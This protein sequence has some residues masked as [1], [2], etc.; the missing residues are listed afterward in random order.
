M[1]KVRRCSGLFLFSIATKADEYQSVLAAKT[2]RHSNQPGSD[3]TALTVCDSGISEKQCKMG[4]HGNQR[5]TKLTL[6]IS[7]KRESKSREKA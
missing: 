3:P 7:R 6:A 1:M 2:K 5:R 4:D